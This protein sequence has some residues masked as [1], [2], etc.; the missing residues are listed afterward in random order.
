MNY[1]ISIWIISHNRIIITIRIHIVTRQSRSGA[2]ITIRIQEP[3]PLRVIVPALQ[4][5]QPRI[6]IVVVPPVPEGVQRADNLLLRRG[7]PGGIRIGE[8]APGI[9]SVGADLDTC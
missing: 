4:I 9:V 1:H 7:G 2:D 6:G 3:S 8:V 5:V